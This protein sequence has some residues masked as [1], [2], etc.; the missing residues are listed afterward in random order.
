MMFLNMLIHSP[1]LARAE[2][3]SI[4]HLI[5]FHFIFHNSSE[6]WNYHKSWDHLTD[7]DPVLG[8][9]EYKSENEK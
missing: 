5:C 1:G 4:F 9:R 8:P 7:I 6:S 2:F 3:K